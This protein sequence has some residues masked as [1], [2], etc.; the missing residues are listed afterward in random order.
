MMKTML[1]K[2][3]NIF[4]E[5]PVDSSVLM[6][7]ST[8]NNIVNI[9]ASIKTTNI[10]TKAVFKSKCERIDKSV[11]FWALRNHCENGNVL[12]SDVVGLVLDEDSST[13]IPADEYIKDDCVFSSYLKDI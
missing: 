9:I 3:N 8:D 11:V 1:D 10:S 4:N 7:E 2:K 13:L 6:D 5:S 12:Y